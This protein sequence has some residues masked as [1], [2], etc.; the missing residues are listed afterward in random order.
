MSGEEHVKAMNV[1]NCPSQGMTKI[2]K[3][4]FG[5]AASDNAGPNSS[6]EKRCVMSAE[7]GSALEKTRFADSSW[8]STA[9]L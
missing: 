7:T 4:L 5:R 9:A 1:I 2:F 6:N 8:R 3:E